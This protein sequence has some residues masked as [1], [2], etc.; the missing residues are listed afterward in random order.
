[1][2]KKTWGRRARSRPWPR[3]L[4]FLRLCCS[5]KEEGERGQYHSRASSPFSTNV[6]A[7]MGKKSAVK[8]LAALRALSSPMFKPNKMGE[9]T[10]T[11]F[12]SAL[13]VHVEANARSAVKTLAAFST[14]N[15]D[16]NVKTMVLVYEKLSLNLSFEK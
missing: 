15:D 4:N 6:K 16:K 5:H 11:F 12:H 3:S 10:F 8:T 9:K 14:I 13:F 2:L 1:M 7:N